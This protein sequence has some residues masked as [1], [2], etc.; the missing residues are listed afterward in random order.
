MANDGQQFGI[1]Q[2]WHPQ[3]VARLFSTLNVPWWIAGGWA[4]DLFVGAQTRKHE[5]ID[6]Q[7]LRCDQQA[8]RTLLRG[9]DVQEAHPTTPLNEWPFR[10]WEP[11]TPLRPGVHDVWCRLSKTDPWALQLMIADTDDEL[12]LFRRDPRIHRPLPTIGR[13]SKDNIPYLAPEIQL[14]YKAKAPRPK[15]EADF[16]KALPYLDQESRHWL[17][18]GLAIV[19]PVHAWL[20]QLENA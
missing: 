8:V 15:D 16:M 9:W 11:G 4:I 2:P 14:L 20:T 7:V 5:D 13:Q 12:W 1:W 10:E 18:Q 17:A 3:E 19:H 6:V